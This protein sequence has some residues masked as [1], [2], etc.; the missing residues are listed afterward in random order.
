MLWHGQNQNPNKKNKVNNNKETK[1]L[2]N[3]QTLNNKVHNL[4]LI[5]DRKKLMLDL[6]KR[7]IILEDLIQLMRKLNRYK[8]YV[9]LLVLP[10]QTLKLTLYVLVLF[11]VPVKNYISPIFYKLDY[12]DHRLF[13]YLEK[14]KIEYQWFIYMI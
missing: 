14:E 3:S 2:L 5:K 10:S 9:L 8:H 6:L 1:I 12:K 7:I 11:M 13:Q 4:L